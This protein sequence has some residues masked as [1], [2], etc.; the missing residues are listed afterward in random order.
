[1]Q[2]KACDRRRKKMKKG[3]H[4]DP[5]TIE[6]MKVVLD[7]AW[8][9]LSPSQQRALPKSYLA[10]RILSAAANGERDPVRLLA[11]ALI[12]PVDTFMR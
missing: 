4:F 7:D 9:A 12:A 6:I 10:E 11:R 1:M 8:A 5:E 2:E 3:A